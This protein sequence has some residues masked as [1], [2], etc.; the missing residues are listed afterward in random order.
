MCT[1]FTRE[2]ASYVSP[3]AICQSLGDHV[4]RTMRAAIV[5]LNKRLTGSVGSCG[6]FLAMIPTRFVPPSV[7]LRS[8]EILIF[9]D[10]GWIAV[11]R[12]LVS[13]DTEIENIENLG[14]RET[15]CSLGP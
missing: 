1:L 9:R 2:C 10:H 11:S 13:C 14:V 8:V 4:P 7:H 3:P 12:E 15:D 6:Q 5:Q